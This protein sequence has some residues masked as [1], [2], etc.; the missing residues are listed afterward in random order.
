VRAATKSHSRRQHAIQSSVSLPLFQ[1]RA[2]QMRVILQCNDSPQARPDRVDRSSRRSCGGGLAVKLSKLG[3]TVEPIIVCAGQ[4]WL[5]ET[6]RDADPCTLRVRPEFRDRFPR[7]NSSLKRHTSNLGTALNA[8]RQGS[9]MP[10]AAPI[11]KVG[12]AFGSDRQRPHRTAPRTSAAGVRTIATHNHMFAGTA[13]LASENV[14]RLL[15]RVGL[16]QA[17]MIRQ[18][19]MVPSTTLTPT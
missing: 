9:V 7:A 19:Q 4:F 18:P 16:A 3:P 17:S 14:H 15:R 11:R 6:A 13:Q 1:A 12:R 2:D 8:S 5:Y 10:L